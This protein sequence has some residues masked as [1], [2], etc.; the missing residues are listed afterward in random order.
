MI[1]L[2][3][4]LRPQFSP[5]LSPFPPERPGEI[6]ASAVILLVLGAFGLFTGLLYFANLPLFMLLTNLLAPLFVGFTSTYLIL[7]ITLGLA[8][9]A[10]LALAFGLWSGSAA[11]RVLTLIF[12]AIAIIIGILLMPLGLIVLGLG[13]TLIVLLVRSNV[14]RYIVA[15]RLLGVFPLPGFPINQQFVLIPTYSYLIPS[16][17]A[18]NLTF[19][20]V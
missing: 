2:S 15:R 19:I 8:S 14:G 7:A 10:F 11:A 9:I 12:A 17:L 16:S 18:P 5:F 3:L 20:T 1:R 6:V 4:F 13:V